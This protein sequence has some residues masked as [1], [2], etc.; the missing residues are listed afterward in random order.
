MDMSSTASLVGS[1]GF[2]IVACCGLALF[3]A[4][5]FRGFDY[6]MA[7]NNVLTVELIALLVIDR[8]DVNV[9]ETNMA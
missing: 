2:P 4:M 1:V 5:A 9:D 3:V 8:G 6:L 7:K